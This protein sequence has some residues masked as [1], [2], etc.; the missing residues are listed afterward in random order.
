VCQI[1]ESRNW[2]ILKL[3]VKY[4]KSRFYYQG[5]VYIYLADNTIIT[6]TDK[7]ILKVKGY[8][9]L[10]F[11]ILSKEIQQIKINIQSIRFNFR[12]KV[13]QF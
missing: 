12:G 13:K 7:V 5:T 4:N 8:N 3:A 9:H 1:E 2:G 11:F 10:L 6:C